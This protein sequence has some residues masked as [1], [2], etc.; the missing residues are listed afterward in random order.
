MA[1]ARVD[2]EFALVYL[3]VN[4]IANLATQDEQVVCFE[5][6][7]PP[8]GGPRPRADAVGSRR[9]PTGRGDTGGSR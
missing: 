4:T 1:T 2:G 5:N 3:V 9:R 6:G 7:V 8:W